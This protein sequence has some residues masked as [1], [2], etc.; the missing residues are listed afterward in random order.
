MSATS[1][2]RPL[3]AAGAAGLLVFICGV[4]VARSRLPEWRGEPIAAADFFAS[5]FG[6][7][8][9]RAGLSPVEKPKLFL[10]SKSAFDED[11]NLYQAGS[12]YEILGTSAA[13]WL[14]REGRGPYVLASASARWSAHSSDRGRLRVAFSRRGLPVSADW[15]PSNPFAS[16]SRTAPSL[17]Q[18]SALARIFVSPESLARTG[19]IQ[20]L[21]QQVNVVPV[22][23]TDPPESLLFSSIPGANM[24]WFQRTI[25]SAT[26]LRD[27][28]QNFELTDLILR[29]L[30]VILIL[31]ALF[32]GTLGLFFVLL[33]RRRIGFANGLLLAALS[34]FFSLSEPLLL[35]G[36]WIQFVDVLADVL[37]RAIVIFVLWSAAESWVRS[38]VPGFRTSLDALRAGRLGPA[39]GRALLL[40][41]SVGAATAGVWLLALTISSY[42][43]GVVADDASVP[44]PIFSM[45]GSPVGEGVLRSAFVLMAVGAGLRLPWL[46]RVSFSGTLLAALLL[47]TR[48]PVSGFWFAFAAALL[49]GGLLA[50][51]YARFGLSSLLT[52]AIV[53]PA[54]PA[55]VYSALQLNWLASSFLVTAGLSAA[56][57]VVGLMGLGRSKEAEAGPIAVPAFVRRMEQEQR[58]QHE[59]DLLARMQLGLLPRETPRIAGYEFAARSILAT[60]AGGDLYDFLTDD[61]G[62]LWVA[63]GDVSGHGYSCAIAQAMTKAGLA[64]L[65][66]PEQTPAGVLT[67]LDRVLRTSGSART[68][69]SLALLRLDPARANGLI[70]NAG[71]P[72]PLLVSDGRVAELS[73]SA[74][75][76]GQ[77]PSRT[78]QDQALDLEPD[79]VLVFCSDGLF[80]AENESGTPYGFDRLRSLLAASPSSAEEILDQIMADWRG[81]I[82]KRSPVDD[83]TVVVIRRA[84][85]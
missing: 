68:F 31:T 85:G 28:L 56:P 64:S 25:G 58:V 51:T 49:F 66:G 54:L 43:P 78:Y 32:F 30:P 57:L 44:L 84:G 12:A 63:A 34:F 65:V 61:R 13:E 27:Q 36:S 76:L 47:A 82:G 37:G 48:F 11:V 19:S 3:L 80:E 18:T 9:V 35:L 29:R 10:R 42:V 7:A 33:A 53:A 22:P 2:P 72:Y 26:D 46:R 69:T 16:P 4:L 74:L 60:E 70:A 17:D 73:L 23:E 79:S 81:F 71:H 38:T 45:R 41:W 20:V 6:E 8:A 5:R 24:I 39:G 67:R 75:P 50:F 59:M 1:S 83:T 14:A 21:G 40:G 52:A 55:A 15:M 62:R 77:G